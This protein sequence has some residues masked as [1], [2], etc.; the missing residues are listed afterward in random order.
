MAG[1][2][3]GSGAIDGDERRMGNTA[4]GPRFDELRAQG[5]RGDQDELTKMD[6]GDLEQMEMAGGSVVAA[7]RVSRWCGDS[8]R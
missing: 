6:L 8:V 3:L 7:T 5:E 1:G 4:Y 2:E